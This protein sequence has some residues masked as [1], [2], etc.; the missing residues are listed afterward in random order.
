M[1]AWT[2]VPASTGFDHYFGIPSSL[3]FPP[4]VYVRDTGVEELP[5]EW[6]E[7]SAHRRQN[8][9]GFWRAGAIAPGFRHADVLPRTTDEAV[10]FIQT[11]GQDGPLFLYVAYSAPHTPWLPSETSRHTTEAGYYGDFVADVDRSVG[12]I[13]EAVDSL[14][15]NSLV[16][17]TSDNGAHWLEGDRSTFGHDANGPWRGQK[18]DIWEGGHRVPFIVRWPGMVAPGSISTQLVSHTDLLA[19]AASVLGTMLPADAGEDSF[20]LL[21]A[22]LSTG[23][24][25]RTSMVHHSGDGMFAIRDKDWKLIEGRGS[26]GF[27]HPARYSPASDEPQGQLYN[28]AQ[29]PGEKHN[30]YSAAPDTA[31]RLAMLLKRIQDFPEIP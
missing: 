16:L 10:D 19:T 3:D 18:A 30:L 6:V 17:F 4:Y 22:L 28:L 2:Q 15:R 1:H 29:D 13:L 20:D 11:Y 9:G 27:T 12:R 5:T 23:A 31:A 7:A 26:G 21:P 25:L 14:E 24:G 8:G